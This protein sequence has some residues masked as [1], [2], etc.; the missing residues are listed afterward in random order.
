MLN[1]E[2]FTSVFNKVPMVFRLM[3]K[4]AG[5]EKIIS[6]IKAV[7]AGGPESTATL[8]QLRRLVLSGGDEATL[9]PLFEEWFDQV[10]LPDFAVGKPVQESRAG[11]T[12]WSV[13][14]ANFGNGGGTVEVE[15]QTAGGRVRQ[16]TKVEAEGYGQVWF[17]VAGEPSQ[18]R[19]DPDRLYL[20]SSYQNDEYPRI[21]AV[22]ELLGQGSMALVQGKAADAEAK[23]K[24]VVQSSPDSAA[25]RALLARALAAL[26]RVEEAEREASEALKQTPPS[27]TAL[28]HAHL[29]LGEISLKRNQATQAVGHF[30][31]AT[32]TLAEDVS[33]VAARDD[34]IR[35]E[36]AADQLPKPD[37]AVMRFVSQF[38]TAV[39][40]GRPAAV[41]ELVNA[42]NLKQFIVGV[43]FL[44]GW[45]TEVL[46]GQAL[47]ARRVIL[48][49]TTRA[50][51]EQRERGARAIYVLRQHGQGWMLDHIPVFVEK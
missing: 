38:D 48:D 19:V 51:T 27:L 28:A 20:Q 33:L 11:R 29:A 36:R 3:E 41:R 7:F 32:Y 39:S 1:R 13:T 45:K 26:G 49:V 46:R 6:A 31:Q 4:R 37:E 15:A 5:R 10:V 2:Y 18:V 43:S 34:L 14:V 24:Q 9:K 35:A 22:G 12:G 23:L 47:D 25:G 8:D 21:A 30:R 42:A 44:R 16:T 17:E 40:T 50:T